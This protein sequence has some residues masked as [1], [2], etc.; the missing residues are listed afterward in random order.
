MKNDDYLHLE[1]MSNNKKIS[2]ENLDRV[3][4]KK[5]LQILKETGFHFKM[6]NDSIMWVGYDEN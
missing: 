4:K 1:I 6:I 3:T 5:I 2:I